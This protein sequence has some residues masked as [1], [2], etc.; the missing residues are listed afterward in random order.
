MFRRFEAADPDP[1]SELEYVNPFTL[2]VAVVL[3]AQATDASVN[4]ATRALFKIADTPEKM[5]RARRRQRA[6]L[7]QDHRPLP[8]QGAQRASSC[9]GSSSPITAATFRAIATRWRRCRASAARPPTS[10]STLPSAS[11]RWPSIRTSSASRT[12]PGCRAGARRWRWRRICCASCRAKYGDARAPLAD[13]ARAL[14]VQG[15]P[16]GMPAVHHS[17]TSAFTRRKHRSL[18][19]VS[20]PTQNVIPTN[21]GGIHRR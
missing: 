21:D 2:L 17:A 9:R 15:A 1:K 13:P 10:F 4:K 19:E 3:S 16:A 18:T 8:Q 14:C 20:G 7:H 5:V 12:A 11:R 6:R